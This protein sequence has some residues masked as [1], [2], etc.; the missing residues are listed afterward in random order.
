[1]TKLTSASRSSSAQLFSQLNAVHMVGDRR[2]LH[3]MGGLGHDG[4]GSRAGRPRFF[5]T[6][7]ILFV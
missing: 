3:P 5:G 2:Q 7:W 1:V 6:K 4:L